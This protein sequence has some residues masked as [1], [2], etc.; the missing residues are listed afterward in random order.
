MV[1]VVVSDDIN[2]IERGM[3]RG[4]VTNPG[5]THLT[6]SPRPSRPMSR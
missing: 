5:S 4:C 3:H 6:T 2:G 1:E